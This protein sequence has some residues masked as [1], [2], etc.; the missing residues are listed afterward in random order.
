MEEIVLENRQDLVKLL[1]ETKFQY[2]I[3]KFKAEWCKP[4]KTIKSYVEQC[5]NNKIKEL[6][7][8]E[9]K[10]IFLFIEV[11]ID[12]CFDLYSYLKKMKRVNGV[13]SILFYNKS[14]YQH[15]EDEY[16]YIPQ[17]SI[18]GFQENRIKKLFDLI[19]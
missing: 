9:K 3:L 5:V 13:P 4:C 1:N 17:M 18:S 15:S 2:I 10:D 16:K 14:I 6:N 7:K 8:K 19:Q 12:E 11:D